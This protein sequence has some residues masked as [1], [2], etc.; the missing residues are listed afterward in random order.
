[1]NIYDIKLVKPSCI[2]C[3]P[4][5]TCVK[6]PSLRGAFSKA[7]EVLDLQPYKS[8]DLDKGVGLTRGGYEVHATLREPVTASVES[9]S[10]PVQ[11]SS[12]DVQEDDS[13]DTDGVQG[14]IN[15]L[16]ETALT[17]SEQHLNSQETIDAAYDQA[18]DAILSDE[19]TGSIK[20]V[21]TVTEQPA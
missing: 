15:N 7:I 2:Q 13:S 8:L 19:P 9:S 10:E 16:V 21:D 4:L 17:E 6:A 5:K 20:L 3:H 14:Q 1:M 12:T 11:V 18:T